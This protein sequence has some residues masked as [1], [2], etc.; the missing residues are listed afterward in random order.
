MSEAVRRRPQAPSSERFLEWLAR[1]AY[2]VLVFFLQPLLA[3]YLLHR[4]LRQP[5]YRHHWRERFWGGG[6]GR[7]AFAATEAPCLTLWLHAVSVGETQAAEP[8]LRAWIA[9]AQQDLARPQGTRPSIRL[10]LTHTTPTG[11]ET[12]ARRFADLPV[13]QFRQAYLPYDLPWT[14]ARFLRWA[15]PDLGI[16]METELWPSLLKAAE[17][18]G[19]P[20]ALIN[21]RLSQKSARQMHRFS[22]LARPSLA[23]L[24]L[25]LAQTP[26]DA[27]RFVSQGYLGPLQ[28]TGS[29]KFD[30]AVDEPQSELGRD[31]RR[32]WAHGQVWLVASSRD[33]EEAELFRA[34]QAH[35]RGRTDPRPLLLVVPRHPQR[36]DR[37]AELALAQG[38]AL[39][40]RRDLDLPA[41]GLDTA[42]DVLLGDS[43]GEMQAY[44][45]ASDLVLIGGSLLP[46]GGQNPLEACAQGRPVFF[47]PSMFNFQSIA[48]ALQASG[49]GEQV[50]S[51]AEFLARAE[52]L[53]SD[54]QAYRSAAQAARGFSQ[55]HRGASQRSLE[56]LQVLDGLRVSVPRAADSPPGGR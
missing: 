7:Q 37:V 25:L 49:A 54:A 2:V 4:S 12:G 42:V 20:M 16:L 9:Q 24:R 5:D 36:F 18:R 56:A 32:R 34:W 46:L 52:A 43:L 38:L 15:Q 19:L 48:R 33:D 1:Q 10:L 29:L 27:Q 53:M 44:V 41:L 11:R 55:A 26:A 39:R 35:W 30:V 51:A 21:A 50:A 22:L 45:A 40:R 14:M 3:A 8:L 28:V 17:A 23:R 47:G 31:W 6:A 13:D